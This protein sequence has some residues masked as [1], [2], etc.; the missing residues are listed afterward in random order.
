MGS[1]P[2]PF[3]VHLALSPCVCVGSLLVVWLIGLLKLSVGVSA[4]CG[5]LVLYVTLSHDKLV[6][7]PNLL[8]SRGHW[9]K[10][11][12]KPEF[13]ISGIRSWMD[14]F[15]WHTTVV[16][17]TFYLQ[18]NRKSNVQPRH[19]NPWFKTTIQ[20]INSFIVTLLT[21]LIY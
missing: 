1:N 18:Q 5:W 6:T 17:Q 20:M 4:W 9:E 11:S 8:A 10:L 16:T 21:L 14:R 13:R 19:P 2:R 15:Y 3:F 12:G 7:R